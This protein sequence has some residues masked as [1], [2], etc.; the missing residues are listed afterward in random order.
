MYRVGCK[1][2]QGVDTEK[3]GAN[4][5]QFLQ[6]HGADRTAL[7]DVGMSTCVTDG[8]SAIRCGNEVI[9]EPLRPDE[10]IRESACLCF[11]DL[12]S[13]SFAR[14]L[15]AK[16]WSKLLHWLDV[17]GLAL[18]FLDRM[19]EVG[20][21]SLLP[22]TIVNRLECNLNENRQRTLGLIGES[23]KLQRDFQSAD[24][25]YAVMKGVSLFPVSVPRLELRHQFDLDFL[26]AESDAPVARKILERH[27]YTP[28]AIAGKCWEFKKGQTTRVTAKDL[29]RDLPYRG[30]ELHLEGNAAAMSTR[31]DR[32]VSR[33]IHGETMPVLSPIDLFL[34]QAMHVSKD[35]ASPFLRASHLLEFY[36]HV[37]ARRE[38]I[39]FWEELRAQVS[40]D[41]RE[42]LA[43][44]MAAYLAMSIWGDFV[45]RSLSSWTVD[46][47]PPPIRLWLD[48]YGR[49]TLF[50]VPPG[51]KRYLWLR[52]EVDL[53]VEIS[54]GSS[55]SS[56]LPLRLPH[57]VITATPGEAVST[58]VARCGLQI[59]YLASRLRFHFVESVRLVIESRR[60]RRLR[61]SPS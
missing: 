7:G 36:R 59:R 12:Y 45:P 29:Y 37:L 31:L 8:V 47:L 5:M 9:R 41:R 32:R 4:G 15:T 27:G 52:Q 40:E 2:L 56:L 46:K 6:V 28:F 61:S 21:R 42:S 19:T 34:G 49:S 13:H 53:A 20:R 60:W 1:K 51:N 17:S 16:E 43:I 25:R 23:V 44:G 3:Q 10:R 54:G 50:Q 22:A 55:K 57:A 24:L 39:C 11:S 14:T 26:I 18:C 35:I 58:R 33:E 30:V 48:L 38:D